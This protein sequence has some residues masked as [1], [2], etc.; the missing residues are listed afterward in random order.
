MNRA[1]VAIALSSALAAC[2]GGPENPS[3]TSSAYGDGHGAA[4][5][6]SESDPSAA[7]VVGGPWT[8]QQ[9]GTSKSAPSAGYCVG[10]AQQDNPDVEPMRPY[11]FPYTVGRGT[12]LQGYFDYRPKDDD[13]AIVAAW[14]DDGGQ[15]WNFQQKVLELT[16][17]CPASDAA[18]LGNDDGQG[19]PYVMTVAGQQLLYTLDRTAGNVDSAGLAVHVLAGTPDAPLDPTPRMFDVTTRTTGLL[20]PDGIIAVVPGSDPT[21]ILYLQK[22][23]G[24]DTGFPAEQ[25]CA[26]AKANHDVTTARIATTTDGVDFTDLGP[27]SGL[28]DST[29]ASPTGTRWVGPRGTLLDL[30]DR[31][32]LF[33]TGGNCIDDD[34]DAFHFIGYAESTDLVSWTVVDGLDNPVAA[35]TSTTPTTPAVVGDAQD[36]FAG[37]VYGPSATLLDDHT[38]VLTFAGYH[39]IKPKDAYD[40]YR[41]V[42]SV[43]L[44]SSRRIV[45]G[46][47]D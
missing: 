5:W 38:V 9:T 41:T 14:S 32:G 20:D 36:W 45:A 3:T 46:S 22:Q 29:D 19:H 12:F 27:V 26:N 47:G 31:W 39:T 6:R 42:G 2:S 1:F 25:Q 10:G 28:N 15:S 33:F 35:V 30:G 44:R 21:T 43:V 17:Q 37:R 7:L 13:E 18:T 23:L 24:A 40:D 4:R 11:Y 8:L 16:T 34:S